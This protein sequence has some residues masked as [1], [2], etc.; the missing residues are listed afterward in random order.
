MRGAGGEGGG[1]VGGGNGDERVGS[2]LGE[3]GGV[4]EREPEVPNCEGQSPEFAQNGTTGYVLC[5]VL[6]ES[7]GPDWDRLFEIA[8]GQAGYVT[9]KQAAEAGYST[10]LLRKHIYAG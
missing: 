7:S 1:E 10:H 6:T 9:T 8:A 5:V 4:H 3:I 2:E